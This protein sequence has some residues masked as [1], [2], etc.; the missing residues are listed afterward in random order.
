MAKPKVENPPN[1]R[2][3][4]VD[5]AA[6]ADLARQNPGEWVKAPVTL[7]SG[8]HTRLSNGGVAD[9]DP[10]KFEFTTRVVKGKPPHIRWIYLRT[11]TD[12]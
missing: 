7:T 6:M 8:V 5:W 11:R 3:R 4:K 10:D 12:G 9:I 1:G 2:I